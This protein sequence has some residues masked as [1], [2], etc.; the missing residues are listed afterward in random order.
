MT[1]DDALHSP[2]AP[3]EIVDYDPAWPAQFEQERA[4]LERVLAPWLVGAIEHIGSTAVPGLAA[5]PVIDIMAPVRDLASSR[6]AIDALAPLGYV[7]HPYRP[8]E[9][10]WFCKPSAAFRTHHL[11]LVPRSSALWRERIGFRDALRAN[12]A[13]AAEYEQLKRRLAAIHRLDRE[14]YTDAKSPFVRRVL[15]AHG[16]DE[17]PRE[18][19]R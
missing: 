5:K 1:M 17:P 15:V 9:M 11:H 19:R 12:R 14:A 2:E 10:H 16:V 3:V 13:L 8:D 6:A 7:H 4:L 18:P